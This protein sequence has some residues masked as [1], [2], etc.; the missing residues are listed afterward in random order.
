V[1][2]P[3]LDRRS[4]AGELVLVLVLVLVLARDLVREADVRADPP[5]VQQV[6]LVESLTCR[7]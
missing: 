7:P 2:D 1:G 3:V 5:R 6:L 4:P